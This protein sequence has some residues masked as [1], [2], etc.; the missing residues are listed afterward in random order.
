VFK[1]K[2]LTGPYA[3][4]EAIAAKDLNN[5]YLTS[6]YF[7]DPERYQAFCALYAV[8]R[9]VDDRIDA[10]P[11]RGALTSSEQERERE[12]VGAWRDAFFAGVQGARPSDDDV[13][14]C[15]CAGSRDLLEASAQAMKSFPVALSLWDSFFAAMER[16]IER[17]RFDTYEDFL[18]YSKGA[19]VA[20]TTIYL[21]LIVSKKTPGERCLPPESFDLLRCGRYLGLFAYIAHI[22]RDL[23]A[24]LAT[25]EEG[26]L[27]LAGDDMRHFHVTEEM[28]FA[29]QARHRASEPVRALVREL[30][31]RAQRLRDQGRKL[32]PA[33]DGELEPDCAFILE[34][35]IALYERTL[36][37]IAVNS[38]DPFNGQ[39]KLTTAEKG[40][41][42]KEVASRLRSNGLAVRLP[43][44]VN[45]IE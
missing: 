37:K 29:D 12:V 21:N 20:P 43:Q 42:V 39:H 6:C 30:R 28:L 13:D 40:L 36:E 3:I 35:I 22:L 34:L 33:L 8:M 9:V 18:E 38:H 24:D 2:G 45:K 32:L 17:P 16:D 31:E 27:Y 23:D 44:G 14:R 1:P 11:S 25:G 41:V 19:T 5:L 15:D 26:L 4:A 10:L 7:A